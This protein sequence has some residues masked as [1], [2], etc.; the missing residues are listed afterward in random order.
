[1][2]GPILERARN[3]QNYPLL[4][5]VKLSPIGP[6]PEGARPIGLIDLPHRPSGLPALPHRPAPS[7]D[8]QRLPPSGLA[9]RTASVHTARPINVISRSTAMVWRIVTIWYIVHKAFA[10]NDLRHSQGLRHRP[11][12][13]SR[14]HIGTC[15]N[16]FALA[17]HLSASH[18]HYP[19]P[20]SACPATT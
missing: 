6:R 2:L 7:A 15:E 3:G 4:G 12:V 13:I 10:S 16:Y 14:C 8:P 1:M 17:R 5:I 11:E 9:S 19:N 20:L 18:Q